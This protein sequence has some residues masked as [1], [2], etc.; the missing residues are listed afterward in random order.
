MGDLTTAAKTD[1][2]N[3]SDMIPIV[4]INIKVWQLF[5]H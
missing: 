4:F 1:F 5:P 2:S 3:L